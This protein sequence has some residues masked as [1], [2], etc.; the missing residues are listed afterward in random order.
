[1]KRDRLYF[2]NRIK[3]L[4][5]RAKDNGRIIKKLQRQLKTA[6]DKEGGR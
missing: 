5:S 6:I 4:E 1:M 2:E 3:L